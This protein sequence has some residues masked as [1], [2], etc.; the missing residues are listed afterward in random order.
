MVYKV[1]IYA[2]LYQKIRFLSF[3]LRIHGEDF[4]MIYQEIDNIKFKMNEPF[5]FEFLHKY[6]TVFKVF[7]D[8]DS[9]NIY[10]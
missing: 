9:G 10:S 3:H 4:K 1:G 6:G 8:Q 2:C 5:D 7:D